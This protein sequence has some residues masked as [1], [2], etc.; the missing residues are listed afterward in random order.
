ML[1]GLT[2]RITEA[3]NRIGTAEDHIF[4][5]ETLLLKLITDK[6]LLMDKVKSLENYSSHNKNHV[7]NPHE[8]C[9]GIDL[10][11]F[12]AHKH[13]PELL[14]LKGSHWTFA[15]KPSADEKPAP[16]LIRLLNYQDQERIP[17]VT[18]SKCRA[19]KGPTMYENKPVVLFPNPGASLVKQRKE[20][21][22]M[23]K[24]LQSAGIE[25]YLLYPATLTIML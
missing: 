22:K 19:N 5:I 15:P 20:Y 10:V 24:K 4:D 12:T 1:D 2:S 14:K 23:K 3:E 17:H 7:V 25:Y 13:F 21:D 18:T 16:V 11:A 6:E 9:E 8:N